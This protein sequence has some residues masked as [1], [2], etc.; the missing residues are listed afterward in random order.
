M[1]TIKLKLD[2]PVI[3]VLSDS[4]GETG[5]LVV[6]AAAS[7]FNA[8]NLDIRRIPYLNSSR[9]IEDAL[10]EAA[11]CGAA[12]AY[13]LVR[14]DLKLVLESKAQALK[15]HCV[16][17]MGPLLEAIK[18][19]THT[20]PRLEPG[21]I[22]RLDEAYFNRVEAIEF[23]VKY[24]DGKQPWGLSKADLV[25][26]GV[27]RTSKTPLSMYLAH[28]GLKV[29]NVPIV[30]EIAPPEE[31]F[32]LQPHAVFGLTLRLPMLLE[33]RRERL[34]T[35]GL[36]KS[37][38]YANP[39]RIAGELD[40]AAAIMRKIGCLIIDVSNKAVEETAAT[41]LNHYRKGAGA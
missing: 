26:I 10:E 32:Q 20:S 14:P 7:Q 1:G 17:I 41:I 35:L 39:E 12:V 31:L 25:I 9:E 28:Q 19:V 24:D 13:T 30:P 3:Y 18:S 6:K 16:D 4:I 11:N 34:K 27:S 2:C 23:A 29:A 40:Y 33:I 37:V 36:S 22:H 5:E 38:D 21:L 8:A 15:L